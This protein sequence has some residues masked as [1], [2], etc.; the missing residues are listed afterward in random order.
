MFPTGSLASSDIAMLAFYV[1]VLGVLMLVGVFLRVKLPILKKL[2][3]PASFVG[4]IVGL[5]L[6]S[7]GAGLLPVEMTDTFRALPTTLMVIMFAPM[8]IGTES[9]KNLKDVKDLAI[10]QF[11]IGSVGSFIQTAVPCL[12]TVVLLSPVFGVNELF[13]SIVEIGWAGGHG[14]AGGMAGVFETLNWDEGTSLSLMS[15]TVGLLFGAVSGMIMLSHAVRHGYLSPKNN[16][17]SM[18]TIEEQPDFIPVDK[19]IASSYQTTNKNMIESFALH[20]SIIGVAI[21]FGYIIKYVL[22]FLVEGLPLFPMAMLGGLII[23]KFLKKTGLTKYVDVNT[24]HRIQGI[25]LDILVVAAVTSL[26]LDVVIRHALPLAI[27][28]AASGVATLWYFYWLCP[29]IFKEDWFEQGILHYG[30]MTGV[31]AIGLMLLRAADP[32][33]KTVAT[34]GYAI[35]AP[36]TSPIFG[37]GFYTAL[38]PGM[39][40]SYGNLKVG[41]ACVG[42][43][44]LCIVIAKIT[45]CWHPSLIKKAQ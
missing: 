18:K 43:T 32:D 37:G 27:I 42:L 31:T 24:L 10:P 7:Y 17:T 6:S 35:Q 21:V 23:D 1:A 19:K 14:T 44:V 38:L 26:R 4:G 8:L 9:K 2:F 12:L 5:C 29:R 33:M 39:I 34:E 11:I 30:V 41:L 40:A 36:I 45:G 3:L 20:I 13:P 28:F 16:L 15:A 22:S 25:C